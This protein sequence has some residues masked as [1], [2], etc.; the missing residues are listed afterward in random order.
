MMSSSV[1]LLT[2]LVLVAA[3]LS[4]LSTSAEA[5][6]GHRHPYAPSGF[7]A[8]V[9]GGNPLSVPF[10]GRGWYPGTVHYYGP[11]D[12]WCCRAAVISVKY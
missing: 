10:F 12:G 11:P 4:S 3:C 9:R 6:K 2:R 8:G 5:A 1:Q 7:V